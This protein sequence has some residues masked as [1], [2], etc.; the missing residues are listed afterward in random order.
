MQNLIGIISYLPNETELREERQGLLANLIKKCKQVFP[1]IPIV[2]IAQNWGNLAFGDCEI[3]YHERLGI[4][5]ART[6]LKNYFLG[7]E[8]DNLIMFDDDCI[9][10]FTEQDGKRYLQEIEE[11]KGKAGYFTGGQLK[12]FSIPKCLY[13]KAE[14]FVELNDECVIWKAVKDNYFYFDSKQYNQKK[15]DIINFNT[16]STYD[17]GLRIKQGA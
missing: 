3:I 1:K 5:Q 16:K 7:N 12:L 4:A 2:V 11:H 14:P 9:L 17:V 13:E 10:T 6:E 15:S 8:Y